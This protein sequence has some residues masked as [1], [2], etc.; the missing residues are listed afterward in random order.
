[1]IK[2]FISILLINIPLSLLAQVNISIQLPPA[3]MIQK[4]QL[5]N[6]VLVNNS[7]ASIEI[8]VLLDLKYVVTGQTVLSGS[9]RKV[10][11]IKGAKM[12]SVQDVQPVQY[13]YG[14]SG[15]NSS[16]LPL[17]AYIAC[18]TLKKS[19]LD[20]IETIASECVNLN[21]NP[22]SP[23]LLNTP[24]DKSILQTSYPQ[25]SW[26]PPAPLQMF[27]DLNYEITVAEV[28]GEQS[29]AD[30]IRYNTPVYSK[31]NSKQPFENYPST[32]SKLDTGKTYA[33]QV[34]ARNGLNYSSTTEVWTFSFLK[35]SAK[36]Q[37]T[38]SSYI[39]L[40]GNADE[41]GVNYI[42]GNHLLIKYYSFDKEHE[43]K[44]RFVNTEGR[45]IKQQKQK[46]IY[47]DN[48]IGFD[49]KRE[50]QQGQVY[51]V[52]ITDQKNQIHKAGFIIK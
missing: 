35:D 2:N 29:P 18:Y 14:L 43:T 8:T 34:T 16:F 6:L 4:D 27:D 15:L 23:P 13:N 40:K 32:Y 12:L 11:L 22:L 37:N 47:G 33:W 44:V 3:G 9:S 30:A 1:M 24:A 48:F 42:E 41:A 5:W 19:T 50:F 52:E 25:F 21:I 20:A 46:I 31:T 36:V 39:L 10:T 49:L 51:R 28:K 26:T 7:N 45:I 38:S 17:G